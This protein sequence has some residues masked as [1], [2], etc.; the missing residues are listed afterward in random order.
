MWLAPLVIAAWYW[1]LRNR[2]GGMRGAAIHAGI[3]WSEVGLLM[4][5]VVLLAVVG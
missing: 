3:E 4:V 5:A 2:L 1:L